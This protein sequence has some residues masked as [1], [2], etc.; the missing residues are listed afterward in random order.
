MSSIFLL[1]LIPLTVGMWA[2]M[3]I[4]STYSKWSKVPSKG[5][6]TGAEAAEAVM[7]KA[8]IFDVEIVQVPGHL[9]DHYHPLKKQLALSSENYSGTSLAALGVA[10][11]EAGH[12][13]Q[14]KQG[15]IPLKFRAALIPITGFASSALPFVVLGGLFLGLMGLIKLGV[16]IYLILT[17]FQL[18]TLPVEF[19]ASARAKKMLFS[20]GIIQDDER[21]G[22]S[23]TLNAAG[24]TYVAAFIA[25]L[26][27]L[28]YFFLL[29]R[30][31]D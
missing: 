12:A 19:D 14:H 18:V 8:G 7:R 26:S 21:H 2:Q 25:S 27:D 23:Q 11:H 17:F 22:V 3:R 6:I 29:S 13:I 5:R 10:A 20:L 1:F 16:I 15:Y 4:S 31:D 30:R 9:T 28:I 24:F